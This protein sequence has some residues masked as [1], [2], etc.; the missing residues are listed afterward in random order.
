METIPYPHRINN[1]PLLVRAAANEA[2]APSIVSIT[3]PIS[4]PPGGSSTHSGSGGGSGRESGSGKNKKANGV[5]GGIVTSISDP[6][7]RYI[8]LNNIYYDDITPS[9]ED[10]DNFYAG[11]RRKYFPNSVDDSDNHSQAASS[12]NSRSNVDISFAT[13]TTSDNG[14]NMSR[15]YT[16]EK[17]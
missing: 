15:S 16:T 14:R 9:T 17:Y 3:S 10:I 1:E 2:P 5:I 8:A 12:N 4:S 6:R 13:T 11:L 7:L